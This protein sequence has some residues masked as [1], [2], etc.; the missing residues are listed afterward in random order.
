MFL[1][2]VSFVMILYLQLRTNEIFEKVKKVHGQLG[3]DRVGDANT[4]TKAEGNAMQK[5]MGLLEESKEE[6]FHRW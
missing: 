5:A 1:R 6:T 4:T 3:M 2:G